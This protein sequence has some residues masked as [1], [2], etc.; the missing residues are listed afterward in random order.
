MNTTENNKLIAEFMGLKI[1][2]DGI[3]F[4][5]TNY[6]A[7]KRYDTDWNWLMEVV[8]KISR[9]PN[10]NENGLYAYEVCVELSPI[11]GITIED[12][13]RRNFG[14]EE[15]YEKQVFYKD[16]FLTNT[17]KAV[18]EFIKWFNQNK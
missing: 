3:S 2:T 7:L 18:V 12:M 5:D 8:E 11:T 9:I 13:Y 1:I 10:R 14:G 17:Y 4:F 15:G 16:D 6:K